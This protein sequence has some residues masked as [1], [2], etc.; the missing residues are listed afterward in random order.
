[1]SVTCALNIYEYM[2]VSGKTLYT[3][4]KNV[5]SAL[6]LPEMSPPLMF[7][8]FFYGHL[9]NVCDI[10]PIAIRYIHKKYA[11]D[12]CRTLVRCLKYFLGVD[13]FK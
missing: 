12:V 10:L 3:N 5:R 4:K 11:L 9:G 13:N 1:M 8:E 7:A 2:F 6:Y